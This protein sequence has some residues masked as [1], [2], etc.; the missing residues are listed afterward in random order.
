MGSY[1]STVLLKLPC[2]VMKTNQVILAMEEEKFCQHFP[3]SLVVEN[4][5]MTLG[6]TILCLLI[7]HPSIVLPEAAA[8]AYLTVEPVGNVWVI[9]TDR[10]TKTF[11]AGLLYNSSDHGLPEAME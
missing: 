6:L 10:S 11:D 7:S 8:P 5:S 2:K 4:T 1:T 3:P 9:Y